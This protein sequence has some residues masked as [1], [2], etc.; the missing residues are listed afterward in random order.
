MSMLLRYLF[1]NDTC[2]R[3]VHVGLEILEESLE[4]WRRDSDRTEK[5]LFAVVNSWAKMGGLGRRIVREGD[6]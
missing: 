3:S 4:C 6:R 1:L 2:E 5:M